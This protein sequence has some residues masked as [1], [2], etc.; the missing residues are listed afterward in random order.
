MKEIYPWPHLLYCDIISCIIRT[1]P[2]PRNFMA[3]SQQLRRIKIRSSFRWYSEYR[4]FLKIPSSS[5]WCTASSFLFWITVELPDC[6]PCFPLFASTLRTWS[7]LPYAVLPVL[8]L[9]LP[10]WLAL[11]N[12]TSSNIT[13]GEGHDKLLWTGAS[14]VG[15]VPPP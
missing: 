12:E 1:S 4:H 5:L 9:G 2:I 8:P 15:R 10:L 3:L 14:P 6:S 7:I 11:A 13:R